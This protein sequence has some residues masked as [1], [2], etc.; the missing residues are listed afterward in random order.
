MTRI[1]FRA[2]ASADLRRIAKDTRAKWG[3][4]QAATYSAALRDAI[5]SLRDFPLRYPEFPGRRAPFRRMNSGR[6]AV[7]YLVTGDLIEVVRVLH[8]AM[9]FDERLG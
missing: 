3:E 7:F 4:E 5:K 9:D 6:H 8:T 1:K 2:A